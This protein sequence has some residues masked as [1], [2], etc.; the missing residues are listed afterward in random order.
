MPSGSGISGSGIVQ[1]IVSL[2]EGLHCVIMST[3]TQTHYNKAFLEV[4]NFNK[5]LVLINDDSTNYLFVF[6][7]QINVLYDI[8]VTSV[9]T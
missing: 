7:W 4:N 2:G 6:E 8:F 1:C 3:A 9:K 5:S